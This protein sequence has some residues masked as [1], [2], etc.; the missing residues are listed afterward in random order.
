MYKQTSAIE[1]QSYASLDKIFLY[2]FS[3][4][5]FSSLLPFSGN[6]KRKFQRSQS[7]ENF[8]TGKLVEYLV[9]LW[10]GFGAIFILGF[11]RK[12]IDGRIQ[13]AFA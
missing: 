7:F 8:D 13:I 3:T 10:S 11:Q 4:T 6:E 2:F 9:Y 1:A 5:L 12:L